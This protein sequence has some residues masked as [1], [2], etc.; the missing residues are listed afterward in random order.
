MMQADIGILPVQ[1]DPE[2][3]ATTNWHVKSENRLTMKM[4]MGLPVI[5]TPIPA[6]IPV[7]EQAR[8]AYFA[9]SRGEWMDALSELRDPALRRQI[10]LAAR[11]SVLARYS[12]ERQAEKL[13]AVFRALSEKC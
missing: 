9:N 11:Q 6:Y 7:V 10:G 2:L 8:N 5:A 3:G 13:V 4:A 12:A 1:T